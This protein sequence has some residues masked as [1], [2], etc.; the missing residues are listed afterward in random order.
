MMIIKGKSLAEFMYILRKITRKRK[1][2]NRIKQKHPSYDMW[3]GFNEKFFYYYYY[4]F[5][6][7][8]S[9]HSQG[10]GEQWPGDNNTKKRGQ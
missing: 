9:N 5:V 8:L 1:N 7:D 10:T 2:P 4:L 6:Y 3:L